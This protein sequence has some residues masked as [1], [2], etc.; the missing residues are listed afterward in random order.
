MSDPSKT[1]E[2]SAGNTSNSSR[3]GATGALAGASGV[4]GAGALASSTAPHHSSTAPHAATTQA[5][6]TQSSVLPN[7]HTQSSVLP[8]SSSNT[9]TGSHLDTT[10]TAGTGSGLTSG[11][12]GANT[13]TGSNVAGER[14]DDIS[15]ALPNY[16]KGAPQV[17]TIPSSNNNL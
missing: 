7:T 12:T 3:S 13:T 4:A 15:H 1:N 17:G 8:T 10:H 6:T 9:A 14:I 2:F 16:Y 5:A 11:L